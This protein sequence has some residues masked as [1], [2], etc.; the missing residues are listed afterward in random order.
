MKM[1]TA[2]AGSAPETAVWTGQWRRAIAGKRARS[3]SQGLP[4]T[5]GKSPAS[6]VKA[7]RGPYFFPAATWAVSFARTAGSAEEKWEST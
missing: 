1:N 7:A 3:T 4:F 2:P 5:C 6:Q